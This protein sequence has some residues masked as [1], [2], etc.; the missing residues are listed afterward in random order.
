MDG[1][2]APAFQVPAHVP[3]HLVR[4]FQLEALPGM[5]RDSVQAAVDAV[6][7][8]PEIFYGLGARRDQSAWVVTTHDLIR[9][10]YQDAQLF[11]SHENANFSALVGET[12]ALLPL[13]ADPPHHAGWRMLLNPIFAPARMK[14]L[15]AEIEVLAHKLIDDALA[16][17]EADFATEFAAIYPIQ[18]FLRLFGLPLEET[19]NFVDWENDLLHSMTMEGRQRGARNIIGYLRKVIDERRGAATDDVITYVANLQI[20][21]RPVTDDEA[22]GIAI[23]LYAAGLDTVA[24]M[25]GFMFKHLAEHPADQQML[26]DDPALI[27]NAIEELMRAYPI[28]VSGRKVTRDVEFHGV[29]MKAG[30]LVTLATM[31]AGRDAAEFENPDKVDLRR[32]KVSHITFAAGPHRCVGSHLARRELRIALEAWLKRVPPFRVK[33]GE[34]P[35]THGIGVFGVYHLPLVW[36][37][38]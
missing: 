8:G 2:I 28:V 32:E 22:L 37:A 34:T 24:S 26:R 29:Q 16:R 30:D 23:L 12:W 27:P 1:N 18:I 17:G 38:V 5:E 14:T 11:S 35:V 10:V 25:L 3:P 19:D 21:G 9:E 4:D 36:D 13:E 31:L 20:D 7:G 6:R 15:E 33:A